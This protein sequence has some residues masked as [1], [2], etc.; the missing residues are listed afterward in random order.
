MDIGAASRC[1]ISARLG[2][3]LPHGGCHFDR[4]QQQAMDNKVRVVSGPIFGL[5]TTISLLV[6]VL[7]FRHRPDLYDAIRF[8]LLDGCGRTD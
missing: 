6:A 4:T 1:S 7:G 5:G 2:Q 3:A 8:A